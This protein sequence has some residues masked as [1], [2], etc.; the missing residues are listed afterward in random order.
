MKRIIF[1]SYKFSYSKNVFTKENY[2]EL[3]EEWKNINVPTILIGDKKIIV[4]DVMKTT[5]EKIR[6]K[7]HKKS[8]YENIFYLVGEENL[9]KT[10]LLELYSDFGK[11]LGWKVFFMVSIL[12]IIFRKILKNGLKNHQKKLLNII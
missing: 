8:S 2:K 6:E 12:D 11:L 1:R 3:I 5:F 10:T 4:T 9:G 7:I